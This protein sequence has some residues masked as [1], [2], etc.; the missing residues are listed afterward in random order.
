MN[1]QAD[2]QRGQ[3]AGGRTAPTNL[4]R[5]QT[6]PRSIRGEIDELK[7][8]ISVDKLRCDPRVRADSLVVFGVAA[9]GTD[10]PS[11]AAPSNKA[12]PCA[13]GSFPF[14]KGVAG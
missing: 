2:E 14:A 6:A 3:H 9:N 8:L 11:A 10:R 5:C 13:P 1:T 4:M 12:L 7:L